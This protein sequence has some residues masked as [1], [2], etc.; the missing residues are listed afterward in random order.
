MSHNSKELNKS[1][2]EARKVPKRTDAFK[3]D[4]KYDVTGMGMWDPANWG[5]PVT[6]P[7][8]SMA[9]NGYGFPL[10]VEPNNGQG[11]MVPN[12][13]G[14]VNFPGASSFTEYPM[15]NPGAHN[16]PVK[17]THGGGWLDKY[18]DDYLEKA[19]DGKVKT[20]KA[21][22]EF[23]RL[24]AMNTS[25]FTKTTAMN[26]VVNS[27]KKNTEPLDI[28][29][30]PQSGMVVDKRTNQAYYFG[31]KGETGT[32]PVLTGRNPE[33]NINKQGVEY[34][35]THPK[36]RGTPT[37]YYMV[38]DP[39]VGSSAYEKKEYENRMRRLVPI[40]A[41][42]VPAP[43]AKDL[44]AHW[45]YGKHD[46]P[47]GL[48]EFTRR[49]KLYNCPPGSRW[50]S[51]G[52]V[53]MQ[54]SSFDAFT[55]A[56]PKSDTLM[57]LDSKNLADKALLDKAKARIRKKED[58]G[59][60]E[61][62]Q[63]SIV[64]YLA[65]RGVDYSKENRAK[66]A[67]QLGV[68]DYDYSAKKNLELLDR[69]KSS[70]KNPEVV[71]PV[72][73]KPISVAETR[74]QFKPYM[75]EIKKMSSESTQVG[76]KPNIVDVNDP[77]QTKL[78][79][80]ARYNRPEDT[81]RETES[82]NPL[83]KAWEAISHPF[84]AATNLYKYGRLPNN[85]SQGPRNDLDLAAD[86]I[87]PA[88]YINAAG[89]TAKAATTAK[90]Y[91]DIPKA[92]GSLAVNL[93]GD[94]APTAW[95][96]AGMRTAGVAGD[97]LLAFTGLKGVK[98]ARVANRDTKFNNTLTVGKGDQ[99]QTFNNSTEFMKAFNDEA[100]T[101][102]ITRPFTKK[103]V[104]F[105]NKEIKQRGILEV[106]R[107]HPL[108]VRSMA[109]KATIVPEKY[110]FSTVL[111]PKNIGR[112]LY[113]TV[114]EGSPESLYTMGHGRTAG[115]NQ[116]LGIPTKNNPYRVHPESF[117][118][119]RGFTYT[120]PEEQLSKL[121]ERNQMHGSNVDDL[122]H[123][124]T[125]EGM[126]PKFALRKQ[127][128]SG[129]PLDKNIQGKL[130]DDIYE[131]YESMGMP[132]KEIRLELG[133]KAK[134]KY[135][136]EK[137]PLLGNQ[138]AR[139]E[140]KGFRVGDDDM[141]MGSHGNFSWKAQDLPKNWQKWTMEDTWDIN[142]LSRRTNLPESIRNLNARKLLGGKDFTANLDYFHNPKTGSVMPLVPKEYGGSTEFEEEDDYRRGG[143]RRLYRGKTS[144]NIAT[145]L[146][147]LQLRNYTLFGPPGKNNLYDPTS[148]FEKGGTNNW[149]E[150]YK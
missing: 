123:T 24:T 42:G 28:R 35:D 126:L 1:I 101:T 21:K 56:V 44:G 95:D 48:K 50:T 57:V 99:A 111:N 134:F 43:Q 83:S 139:N 118:E 27:S 23:E 108:D 80:Q 142:P 149:L 137:D 114:T 5:Q 68:S 115:W 10:Y 98:D 8:N 129:K 31:N 64:N 79:R 22:T 14:N 110:D 90:T 49:E 61:G 13:I 66:M 109:S 112:N 116:Y 128:F 15:M 30:I 47:E 125:I 145:S 122:L 72:V 26:D 104:N 150:K 132:K 106:Q 119:G 4:I 103:E 12:D 133:S 46:G 60:A 86:V 45:T 76:K 59:Y 75:P 37:G 78:M 38:D 71:K 7:G 92:L 33:Q 77:T 52:C 131:T 20:G 32:F 62:G 88:T 144:K 53:N 41:F 105:L 93:A 73:N 143:Q 19:Q 113:K 65:D 96:E 91:T 107:R 40:S 89:R 69:L 102:G 55:K 29:Q 74:T 117:T 36:D 136:A 34:L 85:F 130:Y 97:A 148:K 39:G 120:V 135:N 25:G 2:K 81:L 58:G 82:Q 54:A 17:M 147:Y 70:E 124:K 127:A 121:V 3:H 67:K 140:G 94:Q 6:I 11:R 100:A 146:N 18:D 9:T 87:N 141:Y 16:V 63:Y 51:F 84:T 138:W